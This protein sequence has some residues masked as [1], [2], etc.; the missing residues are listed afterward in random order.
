MGYYTA[1]EAFN[2]IYMIFLKLLLLLVYV[3]LELNTGQLS[4]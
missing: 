3:S 1:P 2:K 4:M